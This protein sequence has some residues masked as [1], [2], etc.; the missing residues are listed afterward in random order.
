MVVV[1]VAVVMGPVVVEVE[2]VVVVVADK[3]VVEKRGPD[4]LGNYSQA[5]W[6]KL[7]PDQEADIR[8]NRADKLAKRKCTVSSVE[9]H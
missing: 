5:E 7:T 3:V 6:L 8:K 1:V 9:F 4:G 2:V